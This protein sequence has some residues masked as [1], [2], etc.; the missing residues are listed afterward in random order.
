[1]DSGTVAMGLGVL[2]GISEVMSLIPRF[3]SNGI[4]QLAL[5]VVR[6][7]AQPPGGE[8]QPKQPKELPH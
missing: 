4:M 7:L 2:L 5:N 6:A 3:R 1:M 8:G